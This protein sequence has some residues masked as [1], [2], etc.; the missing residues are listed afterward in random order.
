MIG[1]L[2][3]NFL[4]VDCCT[5]ILLYKAWSV[6]ILIM[7][8]RYGLLIKNVTLN[9]LKKYKGDRATKLVISLR[10]FR[11]KERLLRLNLYTLK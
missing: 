2:K 4:H 8:T 6:L 5:F 3:R 11:Y 1:L 9:K 10:K 7:Q